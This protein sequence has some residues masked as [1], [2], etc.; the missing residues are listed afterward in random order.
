L[1]QWTHIAVTRSGSTTRLFVNG[2]QVDTETDSQNYSDETFY[3]GAGIYGGTP[4]GGANTNYTSNFR[5]VK[6]T[7]VYTSD[8]TPPTAPFLDSNSNYDDTTLLLRFDNAGIIDHT[9]KNNLET[10]GNVRISGQ[11]TKFGTGSIYFDG[12]TDRL[13]VP[14]SPSHALS[15]PFTMEFFVYLNTV[16]TDQTFFNRAVGSGNYDL[17]VQFRPSID[18]NLKV[19]FAN[20]SIT[21]MNFAWNPSINT[22][23]HVAITR[24]SSNDVRAFIDGTQASTAVNNTYNFSA[25]RPLAIGY[26]K[27]SAIQH[28]NGYMDEIR[29]TNGVARYTSNFTAP[30]KAFA[31][32]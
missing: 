20:N 32:R 11:Q 21:Y 13:I 10:E 30:T 17:F 7:A 6:G 27:E 12:T 22:W 23:Y 28:F 25:A 16:S 15:G 3:L 4:G 26:N 29:F 14:A 18:T 2:K 1:N 8:F 24:D 31:N 9:M 5:I 19:A